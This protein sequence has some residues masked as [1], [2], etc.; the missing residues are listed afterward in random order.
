[1]SYN[2]KAE[3]IRH[4]FTLEQVSEKLGVHT[5]A[6]SRWENKHTEPTASN[7]IALAKLYGCSPEYLLDLT[8][9]R[10]GAAVV[11]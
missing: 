11:T 3:R 9:E 2:M 5:N 7:L 10:N 1:M 6:I 8:D 4:G